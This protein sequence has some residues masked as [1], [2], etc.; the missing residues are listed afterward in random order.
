MEQAADAVLGAAYG[1]AG[2]RCM[3]IS[4]VVAVG[5][6]GDRLRAALLPKIAGLRMGAGDLAGVDLGPLI[7]AEHLKRVADYIQT[8]VDE[9]AELVVDGRSPE[10]LPD[11]K[12][13]F[14]GPTLFD[15]A[16]AGMRIYR[17]E[18]FGPVLTMVRTDSEAQAL[19]LVNSHEFG[20]GAAIFT[21]SGRAAREFS[22]QVEAGMV[23]VNVAIPVPMAFFSFGGRKR[24]LF[25]DSNIHGAEGV[26]FYTR[27]KTI[28]TRWPEAAESDG[29][30]LDMPTPGR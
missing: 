5:N 24:S 29:Y 28:T 6:A 8:G 9:G 14:L 20:N 4:I 15:H 21:R 2:E 12:G 30:G 11:G 19:A 22:R 16:T 10:A 26:R 23:G 1:S 18:I 13:F 7:T 3:A 27:L 17:E 25:G